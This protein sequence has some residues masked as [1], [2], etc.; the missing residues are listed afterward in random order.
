M[1]TQRKTCLLTYF[2]R[3]GLIASLTEPMGQLWFADDNLVQFL[4]A[5]LGKTERI[6]SAW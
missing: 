5:L 3:F 4:P 1:T 6:D 2:V